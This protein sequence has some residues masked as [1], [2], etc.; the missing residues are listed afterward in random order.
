MRQKETKDVEFFC[1]F[2]HTLLTCI[3]GFVELSREECAKITKAFNIE[4]A[5]MYV[6][7]ECGCAWII[8]I[9]PIREKGKPT[10]DIAYVIQSWPFT[11]SQTQEMLANPP[12]RQELDFH[13]D[14]QPEALKRNMI[15]APTSPTFCPFH[16]NPLQLMRPW[17]P[18]EHRVLNKAFGITHATMYGSPECKCVWMGFY[19]NKEGQHGSRHMF[20]YSPLRFDWFKAVPKR[21]GCYRI[22]IPE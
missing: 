2:H 15:T 6:S 10:G 3:R 12:G 5:A 7:D 22:V 11:S 16:H 20:E 18:T 21:P 9:G 1:P 17:T 13:E 19:G 14:A 4:H 8:N